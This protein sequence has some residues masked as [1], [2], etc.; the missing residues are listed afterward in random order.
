MLNLGYEYQD[1][2]S[3]RVRA[4]AQYRWFKNSFMIFKNMNNWAI[5]RNYCLG[6]LNKKRHEL[7]LETYLTSEDKAKNATSDFW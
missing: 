6:A 5:H 4:T 1:I 7:L 2:A 3:A